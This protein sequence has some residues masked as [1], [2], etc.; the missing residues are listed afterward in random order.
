M[1]IGAE[2]KRTIR[3][4]LIGAVTPSDCAERLGTSSFEG[5][6]VQGAMRVRA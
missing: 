2:E 4:I 1:V 3:R 6:A 5:L